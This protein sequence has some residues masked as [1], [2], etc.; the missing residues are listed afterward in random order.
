MIEN[1][2]MDMH[3]GAQMSWK[4]YKNPLYWFTKETLV[5]FDSIIKN[6]LWQIIPEPIQ[7]EDTLQDF[8]FFIYFVG[9]S[10]HQSAP[11]R[12]SPQG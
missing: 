12:D 5:L 6:N 11:V 4:Y 9:K 3:F 7:T 10:L 2:K 1:H 8:L